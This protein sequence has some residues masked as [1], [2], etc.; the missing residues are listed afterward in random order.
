MGYFGPSCFDPELFQFVDLF[1]LNRRRGKQ[2][3]SSFRVCLFIYF[4]DKKEHSSECHSIQNTFFSKKMKVIG[5]CDFF[6]GRGG[7]G[8]D[9]V[10]VSD[11]LASENF[12]NPAHMILSSFCIPIVVKN[13][14]TF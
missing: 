9:D 3:L 2:K 5:F 4:K 1:I 6:S 11:R 13:A 14:T 7:G 10:K 8:V 12:S